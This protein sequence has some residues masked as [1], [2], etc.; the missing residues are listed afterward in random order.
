[1][2]AHFKD[3]W[4]RIIEGGYDNSKEALLRFRRSLPRESLRGDFVKSFGEKVIADFLFEH[5]ITY[6]Y[7]RNHWWSGIN[8]RPDFTIFKNPKS[9]TI[10]EYFGLKGDTDYDEM[11]N[12]K[13]AYWKSKPDWTLIEFSSQDIS[14]KGTGLFL[15]ILKRSLEG[16]GIRCIRLSE[17]EIWNRIRDRSI[18]RFTTAMVGFIG[19]CRKRS[20]SP[21]QLGSLIESYSPLSPVEGE[22]LKLAQ[23]LYDAYL[24]RLSA[25]GE[26]DFDG[27]MQR[28]AELILGG[29]TL[30]KRRSGEGDLAL[31]RYACIDEFQDFSEL[32]YRLLTAIRA[33]NS[34]IELFCVG[35]DWQAINGFAGS[36]LRF[37]ENFTDYFGESRRL[38]VSTNYR[39]S[40][41][42]IAVGNALMQG[43]GKPAVAH[44]H[45]SGTVLSLDL[46]KFTPS[47]LEI[48]RH[49]G[50]TITP[51][52]LRMA[53]KTITE[54][55]D[56]VIL[57]R[58]NT[59][60]WFVNYQD[61]DSR[62]VRGLDRYLDLIRSF[63]P[64]GIKERITISTVHKYKGLEKRMVIVLDAVARS[65]PLLHSD[66]VF[67]RILG[68]SVEE[69]IKQERRLL[70]VA[71][72]RAIEKLV[73]VT[74]SKN[75]SPFLEEVERRRPIAAINWEEYA[76]VKG[77]IAHLVAK[78]GNQIDHGG[79]PT[80]AIKDLLRAAGYQFQST[81]WPCWAKSFTV[82]GFNLGRLKSEL[83]AGPA[84][85]VEVHILD[86][87]DSLAA[88]YFVDRGLW[89][90]DFDNLAQIQIDT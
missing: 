54:G 82:E 40:K 61:H 52:V 75:T 45:F 55:F 66:W 41:S 50:D 33:N 44:K 42:I 88:R 68:D 77:P 23:R 46:S 69:I 84:D 31:L 51:A 58:R 56:V 27:L 78:V 70:Y 39:S 22:F 60:P 37:F 4:E 71:L 65:Y 89:R 47:M 17:D 11:S 38:S 6:R 43:L 9:G 15:R 83:W 63:F 16:Q 21:K 19:R 90:C 5:D 49:P 36:D 28:A 85:R 3:D 30:F 29:Q 24:N 72:T 7:E 12:N 18:D 64:S 80:F 13:R 79:A 57:C 76:P 59:V 2:L 74:D 53:S 67:A 14:T 20:L 35:D 87:S 86:D 26:E 10:I 32:F 8:Y 34:E 1:M 25:T 48:Q 81:G 62:D 73:I